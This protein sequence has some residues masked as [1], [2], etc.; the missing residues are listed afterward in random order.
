MENC[1]K[2][3]TKQTQKKREKKQ[4][5]NI[6]RHE[7]DFG[8]QFSDKVIPSWETIAGVNKVNMGQQIGASLIYINFENGAQKI[9]TQ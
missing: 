7:G 2:V 4:S 5:K 1:Q 8:N 3:L 6:A 9:N